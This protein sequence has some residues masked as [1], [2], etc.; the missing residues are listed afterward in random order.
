MRV[1]SGGDILL[2]L[3][4]IEPKIATNCFPIQT[5]RKTGCTQATRRCAHSPTPTPI[6]PHPLDVAPIFPSQNRE[7]DSSLRRDW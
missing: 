5:H 6:H 3:A 2:P 4:V 1:M 7:F